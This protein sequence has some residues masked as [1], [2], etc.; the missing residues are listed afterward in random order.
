MARV[1]HHARVVH[2]HCAARPAPAHGGGPRDARDLR[3][4]VGVGVG[5]VGV[6]ARQQ[7]ELGRATPDATGGG[8]GGGDAAAA[9]DTAT[10]RGRAPA[11]D[12]AVRLAGGCR[13]LCLH[14]LQELL[15][16]GVEEGR[17]GLAEFGATGH[18]AGVHAGTEEE[19]LVG[20]VA[21]EGSQLRVRER[22]EGDVGGV[23]RF[24]AGLLAKCE[25]RGAR[26]HVT[27][28][29]AFGGP[30]GAG[31][32]LRATSVRGL[33]RGPRVWR[34]RWAEGGY[35]D[36]EVALLI[37]GVFFLR[38]RRRSILFLLLDFPIFHTTYKF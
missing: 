32:C 1:E 4:A 7:E 13:R 24:G 26:Q 14:L 18:S 36:D 29:E 28:L 17:V 19:G 23:G 2:R 37:D 38:D 3:V 33:G 15:R 34:W 35:W 30:A 11:G 10:G 25:D 27:E 20:G 31:D 22:S 16:D 8:G 5:L 12:G 6:A 21:L 9:A